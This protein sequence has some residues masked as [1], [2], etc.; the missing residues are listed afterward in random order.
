[1]TRWQRWLGVVVGLVVWGTGGA[2]ALAVG[3]PAGWSVVPAAGKGDLIAAS[4]VSASDA[5]AVGFG[6][7]TGQ[8]AVSEHWNGST[9]KRVAVVNPGRRSNTLNGVAAISATNVWAAGGV[10]VHLNHTLVEHWN[11]VKWVRFAAPSPGRRFSVLTDVGARSA[12]DVWAV[13]RFGAQGHTLAMHWDGH[14]WTR[15]PTPDGGQSNNELT[16]VTVLS[17]TNAWASGDFG[18]AGKPVVEHWNGTR[19]S[20]AHTPPVASGGVLISIAAVS[21]TDIWTVGS[22]FPVSGL[23]F[24]PLGEHWNGSAWQVAS[25]PSVR[26]TGLYDDV[27]PRSQ[28]DVWAVGQ[29]AVARASFRSS[30]IAA[31]WNGSGWQVGAPKTPGRQSF[32]NSVAAVPSTTQFWATG[33]MQPTG[34][35]QY[36]IL[37][38]RH[39]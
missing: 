12:S 17:P 35:G 25:P 19:W 27:A 21:A 24:K 34:G 20:I 14:T 30:A 38:E 29:T 15:T 13:G 37:I 31:H 39:C 5:W 2:S 4:A 33:S 36:H 10:G 32:F 9:W 18:G 7:P 28:T 16:S 8:L 6:G 23:R 11:G 1:M 3:C 26:G 22:F